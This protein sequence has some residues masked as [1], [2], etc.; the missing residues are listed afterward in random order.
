MRD[1]CGVHTKAVSTSKLCVVL[2]LVPSTINATRHLL[3]YILYML[4][5]RA[6]GFD[7]SIS[8]STYTTV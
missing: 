3:H 5:L 4:G 7:T 2:R 1:L 8:V 6:C